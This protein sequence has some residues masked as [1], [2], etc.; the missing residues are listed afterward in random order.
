MKDFVAVTRTELI[1]QLRA[2]WDGRPR[3]ETREQTAE[4]IG[5]KKSHICAVLAGTRRDIGNV[6][7]AFF[8]YSKPKDELYVKTGDAKL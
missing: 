8:G 6:I 3:G 4:H 5:V 2:Y 1:E 7:P